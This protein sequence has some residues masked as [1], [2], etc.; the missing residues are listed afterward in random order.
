V[1]ARALLVDLEAAGVH[2]SLAGDDLRFQTRPGVSIAPYRARIAA[3]KPALV[4][5]LRNREP[6]T[7]TRPP[8][9][10]DGRLCPGCPWPGLCRILG[11]RPPHAIHGP[12][13][14]WPAHTSGGG[15][16]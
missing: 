2:L 4:A 3:H 12:C 5:E 8:A 9:G 15:V 7:A 13:P 11:P 1:S 14:A 16:A 6:V 10:W